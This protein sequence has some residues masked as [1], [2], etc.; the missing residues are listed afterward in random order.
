MIRRLLP[1]YFFVF[2]IPLMAGVMVWQSNRYLNLEK[3]LSRLE[4]TQKEWT[5]SNKRLIAVIAE[6]SS[7]R[8]IEE[9]ARNEY[10]LKKIQ[11]EYS[12]QVRITG[13]SERGY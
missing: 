7:P 11:P 3:E 5:E 8:R 12:L 1:L 9:I 10:D 6:F 2:T 4:Q 13:G